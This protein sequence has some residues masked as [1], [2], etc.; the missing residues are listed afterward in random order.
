MTSSN[1]NDSSPV[2][3][4]SATSSNS[5]ET[6]EANKASLSAALGANLAD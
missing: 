4:P 3:N 6:T 1:E 5:P 2:V